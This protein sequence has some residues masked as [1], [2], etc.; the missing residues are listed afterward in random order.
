MNFFYRHAEI[1]IKRLKSSYPAILITGARQTGKTTLLKK[2]T[3]P[4]KISYITFDDPM[5]E[6]SAKTDPKTFMELHPAP[7][8]FD[9][10]QYVPD[11]FRYL[12]IEIDKNRHN[13]MFFLTGSQQFTLME[14]TTETLSGRIGIIQLYP[15]SAREIRKDLFNENFIPKD[16]SIESRMTVRFPIKSGMT[17][18]FGAITSPTP[19]S[20]I[21]SSPAQLP[22]THNTG[23][24]SSGCGRSGRWRPSRGGR[25]G[26]GRR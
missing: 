1:T 5:E 14:K 7:Y 8:T 10:V 15:F 26:S 12:K 22:D 18:H 9:E 23:A 21:L 11:L 19:Y 4:E 20:K 16:F 2:V 24:R 25:R 6:S 13:G 3:E 17:V